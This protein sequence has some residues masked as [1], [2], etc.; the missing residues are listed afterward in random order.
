MFAPEII[1]FII[2]PKLAAVLAIWNIKLTMGRKSSWSTR[3]YSWSGT[4]SFFVYSWIKDAV[5][6]RLT[7][8]SWEFFKWVKVATGYSHRFWIFILHNEV[9]QLSFRFCL[10]VLVCNSF[11]CIMPRNWKTPKAMNC[12][13][14]NVSWCQ[15]SS[16]TDL[17][18]RIASR[19]RLVLRLCWRTTG[20]PVY[21]IPRTSAR[22][23]CQP[24]RGFLLLLKFTFLCLVASCCGYGCNSQIL[25]VRWWLECREDI[26]ASWKTGKEWA[27][28]TK[29]AMHVRFSWTRGVSGVTT[30][31]WAYQQS[32]QN[33]F[34]TLAKH[35]DFLVRDSHLWM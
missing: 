5:L 15:A 11:L 21:K 9:A 28:Y 7:W 25:K 4:D 2:N 23:C 34:P 31:R 12:S 14:L 18:E 19:Q 13:S 32:L 3:E 20:F 26:A 8:K 30:R 24:G 35:L 27:T 16:G 1:H 17:Q 6:F 10:S 29:V 22:W 33:E